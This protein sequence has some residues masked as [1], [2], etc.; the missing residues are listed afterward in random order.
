MGMGAFNK[1]LTIFIIIAMLSCDLD[2]NNSPAHNDSEILI[3][4]NIELSKATVYE[5]N[6]NL[7]GEIGTTVRTDWVDDGMSEHWNLDHPKRKENLFVAFDMTEYQI[8]SYENALQA[9]K[10]SENDD[11]F[12]LLS[13]NAKIKEEERILKK[14]LNG[15][16]YKLYI[17]WSKINHLGK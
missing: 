5:E 8:Q 1:F 13:A 12:I 4:E 6:N 3:P 17:Q 16:Q 15:S 11:A 7:D 2:K 9:W 10:E 14:I